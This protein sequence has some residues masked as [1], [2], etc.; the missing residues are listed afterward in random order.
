MDGWMQHLIKC[1]S[2]GFT[3]VDIETEIM[4]LGRAR[5]EETILWPVLWVCILS[6][7]RI[8]SN[9][10]ELRNNGTKELTLGATLSHRQFVN[11]WNIQ[12]IVIGEWR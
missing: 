12:V 7:K 1:R 11:S 8:Y 2:F 9:R 4:L 10:T 5:D 6:P 3:Y